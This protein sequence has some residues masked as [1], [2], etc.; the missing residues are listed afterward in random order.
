MGS[1]LVGYFVFEPDMSEDANLKIGEHKEVYE[2]SERFDG[3]LRDYK[4]MVSLARKSIV[5]LFV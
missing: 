4:R 2:V 1:L 3:L 5:R